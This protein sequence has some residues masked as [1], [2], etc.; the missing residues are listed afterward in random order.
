MFKCLDSGLAQDIVILDDRWDEAAAL[1]HLRT[2]GR[3][4][5][6]LCPECR[7]PVLV[8]AGELKVRHFAHRELGTCALQDESPAV[9]QA[10]RVLY[11]WLKQRLGD[12]AR[13]SVTVEKRIHPNLPRPVDCWVE[14]AK[15]GTHAYWIL[16]HGFRKRE[17]L[18]QIL[19]DSGARAHFFFTG[20]N[21]TRA[22]DARDQ[23]ELTPTERDFMA[24]SPYARL[25][26]PARDCLHYLDEA[27]EGRL[28]TLRGL[29]LMHP[30]QRYE[31]S[32]ELVTPLAEVRMTPQG[33]F[34]H[35]GEH[36]RLEALLADKRREQETQREKQRRRAAEREARRLEN[37][38]RVAARRA[39][40]L[41][42][43]ED[44]IETPAT[45]KCESPSVQPSS[46]VRESIPSKSPPPIPE[47]TIPR[48]G[49][50]LPCEHCGMVVTRYLSM[51][52]D[53]RTC[54]CMPC[55]ERIQ[56]ERIS[57]PPTRPPPRRW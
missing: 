7:Q 42:M 19:K 31:C 1:T 24:H 50:P 22:D 33:E 41:A 34:V 27:G 9:L 6:L 45:A 38:Q 48:W 14:L 44:R 25:Y 16:D 52:P 23:F 39:A 57:A 56:R 37:E 51:K 20:S 4:G 5:A 2:L 46:V 55:G 30:P 43:D 49:S 29:V 53:T 54:V 3:E 11:D 32:A 28:I 15:G 13:S 36:D 18:R 35:P 21:L 10:R 47:E 12:G 40:I 26:G 17:E 8:K